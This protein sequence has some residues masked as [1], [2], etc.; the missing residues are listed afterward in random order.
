MYLHATLTASTAEAGNCDR[1]N[2]GATGEADNCDDYNKNGTTR[3]C[4][5]IESSKS[6]V[7]HGW[8]CS[9]FCESIIN[10]LRNLNMTMILKDCYM[11]IHSIN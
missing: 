7:G 8:S 6:G 5:H 11:S 2:S 10:I 3:L 1:N 9:D 4:T